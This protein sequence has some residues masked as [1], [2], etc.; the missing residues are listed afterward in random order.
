M[1]NLEK[2]IEHLEQQ[3]LTKQD[4]EY[5]IETYRKYGLGNLNLF[6]LD[7][8]VDYRD[9]VNELIQD[10][11]GDNEII[12]DYLADPHVA[13]GFVKFYIN[14]WTDNMVYNDETRSVIIFKE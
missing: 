4:I 7:R 6:M 3:G 9:F 2:F 11:L 12:S 1:S 13:D 5:C 8:K 14:R 10:K